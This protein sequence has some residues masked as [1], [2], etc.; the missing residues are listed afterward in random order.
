MEERVYAHV[1]A[2]VCLTHAFVYPAI[3]VMSMY[4]GECMYEYMIHHGA[5]M[6]VMRLNY[7]GVCMARNVCVGLNYIHACTTPSAG[8]THETHVARIYMCRYKH[9]C[10]II[11][12]CMHPYLH[13]CALYETYTCR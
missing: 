10:I 5:G 9:A 3:S 1:C 13:A 4:V 7:M 6:Q 11:H 8:V 12:I 2:H